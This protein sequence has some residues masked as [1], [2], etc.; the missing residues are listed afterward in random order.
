MFLLVLFTNHIVYDVNNESDIYSVI[1]PV[2][3]D[4][5][6]DIKIMGQLTNV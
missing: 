5:Y 4:K 3:T 1:I 6:N 2:D